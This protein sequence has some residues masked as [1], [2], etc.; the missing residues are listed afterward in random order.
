MTHVYPNA[1]PPDEVWAGMD[2]AM[3]ANTEDEGTKK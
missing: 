3:D 1:K 2:M